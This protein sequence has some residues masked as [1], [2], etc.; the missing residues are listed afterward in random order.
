MI[1]LTERSLT[2]KSSAADH[3]GFLRLLP[4]IE[5][6][7]QRAFRGLDPE[8]AEDAVADVV[9]FAFVAYRRL[10]ELGKPDLAYATPLANYGIRRYYSG[11]S[12]AGRIKA[13]DVYSPETQQKGGFAVAHLGS[14]QKQNEAWRESLIENCRTPV[15]DQVQFR[16][17]FPA[18]LDGLAHRDRR[19]VVA[20]ARGERVGHVARAFHLSSGRISQLRAALRNAWETF[21]GE[22]QPADAAVVW[23]GAHQAM[24]VGRGSGGGPWTTANSRSFT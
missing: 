16:I 4:A 2:D 10:A 8:T 9:A 19:L 23:A 15:P 1:A 11:R 17:D 21:L 7:A 6:L 3:Q 20:L 5:Q 22:N 13:G 14:P 24:G 18:W 12:V